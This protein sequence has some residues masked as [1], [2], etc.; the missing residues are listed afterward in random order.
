[1]FKLRQQYRNEAKAAKERDRWMVELEETALRDRL[2]KQKDVELEIAALKQQVELQAL[3][4]SIMLLSSTS[5]NQQ[6][7]TSDSEAKAAARALSSKRR[8]EFEWEADWD[9]HGHM[10]FRNKA[11]FVTQWEEPLLYEAMV[12]KPCPWVEATCDTSEDGYGP[13]VYYYNRA[14][15]ESVW[16][17]VISPTIYIYIYVASSLLS[18]QH[19]SVFFLYVSNGDRIFRTLLRFFLP[20]SPG[21]S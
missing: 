9:E 7:V 10:F 4:D 11:T 13:K 21:C 2:L 12:G 20:F 19:L 5:S 1:M 3:K 15:F 6:H 8:E 17:K 14:T 16:E 18:R